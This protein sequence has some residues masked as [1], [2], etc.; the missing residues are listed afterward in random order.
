VHGSPQMSFIYGDLYQRTG[1][2]RYYEKQVLHFNRALASISPRWL[3][4]EAWIVDANTRQWVADANEP[5]AWAQSMV[6]LAFAGM[7]KSITKKNNS[8][9]A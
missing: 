6:V 1:D 4:P 8:A 2:E 9:A 3:T 7:K 5:L